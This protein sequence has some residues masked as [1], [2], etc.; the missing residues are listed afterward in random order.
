V[1][2]AL[3]R[4]ADGLGEL[5]E[6]DLGLDPDDPDTDGDGLWDGFEVLGIRGAGVYPDQALPNWGADPLHKD[7]FVETDYFE[8]WSDESVPDCG[9]RPCINPALGCDTGRPGKALCRC[10]TDE[11]CVPADNYYIAFDEQCH[12]GHCMQRG[13][14][15]SSQGARLAARVAGQCHGGPGYLENPDGKT[16]FALHVDNGSAAPD[17]SVHG[18]WGGV[19]GAQ[20]NMAPGRFPWDSYASNRLVSMS[21]IR[22]GVFRYAVG[23]PGGGGQGLVGGPAQY[24]N[25]VGPSASGLYFIHELGHNLGLEHFGQVEPGSNFN[26]KPHY[27]SLMN[28]GYQWCTPHAPSGQACPWGNVRFSEG[29]RRYVYDANGVRLRDAQGALLVR[30]LNPAD[31]RES[32]ETWYDLVTTQAANRFDLEHDIG[33]FHSRT[34]ASASQF[35][36]DWDRDL[37]FEPQTKADVVGAEMSSLK[38]RR[39]DLSLSYGPQLVEHEERLFLFRV[40]QGASRIS[41]QEYTEPGCDPELVGVLGQAGDDHAP[42]CGTWLGPWTIDLPTNVRSELSAISVP[43]NGHDVLFL[44]YVE[45]DGDLCALRGPVWPAGWQGPFCRPYGFEGPP[46]AVHHEGSLFVFGLGLGTRDPATDLARVQVVQ[47]DPDAWSSPDG[48]SGWQL[49]ERNADTGSF[50]PLVSRTTPAGAYDPVEDSMLLLRT[51]ESHQVEVFRHYSGFIAWQR[52]AGRSW[53][54]PRNPA[55][56]LRTTDH[57]PSFV[58]AQDASSGVSRWT[59][60]GHGD[61][62]NPYHVPDSHAGD[63]NN[64]FRVTSS[65]EDPWGEEDPSRAMTVLSLQAD[66]SPARAR[67]R[68]NVS[69][70]FYRGKLRAAVAYDA[71]DHRGLGHEE[72]GYL[73]QPLADGVF[74]ASLRDVNDV[75]IMGRRMASTLGPLFEGMSAQHRAAVL[76]ANR[77][78]ASGLRAARVRDEALEPKLPYGP[79]FPVP[80]PPPT[81]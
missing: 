6:A 65:F 4:D 30:G 31:L 77:L 24:F 73:F 32:D 66:A 46:E 70:A 45:P 19:S 2:G 71:W 55:V 81:P 58:I 63:V 48:W 39:F 43:R 13:Q 11:D 76:A 74:H 51:N 34:A 44:F 68:R 67:E 20:P 47:I 10:S 7:V 42:L 37:D 29:E 14:P 72:A 15:L 18:D 64:Y 61:T 60:W 75:E 56:H 12:Q 25:S 28:Y 27:L 9:S 3:L 80:V 50:E 33:W 35:H 53:K 69:L 57:R 5:L 36:L 16:G 17:S 52:L 22:H 59:V 26:F 78:S 21:P 41:Y 40:L 54:N 1:G 38:Y 79:C 62:L 8:F 23:Y 49:F